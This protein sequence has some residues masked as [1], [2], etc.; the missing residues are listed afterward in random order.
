MCP[1]IVKVSKVSNAR[2]LA[3]AYSNRSHGRQRRQN[4]LGEERHG[5]LDPPS[6][7]YISLKKEVP[8]SFMDLAK[9]RYS[10]R[11]FT[12]K[13]VE[14][15]KLA[16]VLEAG[17]LSPTAI[18]AQPVTVKV[19]KSPEALEKIR[20]ITRMAYNAPVVLMVCYDEPNCYTA[21]KY[22][23]NFN[24]GVMDASIVTTSMMM[25]ATDLGLATLWARGFNASYIESAFEFPDN[26]KLACLLDVGYADPENGG[27]SPR[28]PVRKSME[29]F[30]SE[31]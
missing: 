22:N 29:E 7:F 16:Q 8:M 4:M 27:P 14:P 6:R 3:F 21:E 13:A 26:L 2:K 28:H 25:Q 15:E 23:D 17:R 18:N 5:G 9:N 12:D 10:C 30:A 11:A 1:K 31:V 24:S 20:G 19:I